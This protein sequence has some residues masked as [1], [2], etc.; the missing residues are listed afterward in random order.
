MSNLCDNCENPSWTGE[1]P[2]PAPPYPGGGEAGDFDDLSNRP[3]YDS[4]ELT[5]STNIPKVPTTA[6]SGATASEDG[7]KG[8]VPAPDSGQEG[9]YLKGDGSWGDVE[10]AETAAQLVTDTQQAQISSFPYRTSGGTL[11]IDS[12]KAELVYVK[13]K[14]VEVITVTNNFEVKDN[15]LTGSP[16]VSINETV[17]MSL[18]WG[19]HADTYTFTTL[20]DGKVSVESEDGTI[21]QLVQGWFTPLTGIIM[22]PNRAAMQSVGSSVTIEFTQSSTMTLKTAKP[23]G[24]ES[25][26]Y[27][28]APGADDIRLIADNEYRINCSSFTSI[29]VTPFD[30]SAIY[31]ITPDENNK[32]TPAKSGWGHVNDGVGQV[33]IALVWSGSRDNDPWESTWFYEKDIPMADKN[34]NA[35]PPA[36]YGFPSVGDVAD[37]V[38][39]HNKQYIQRV[40]HYAYSAENLEIVQALDT[41]YTY[42]STDIFYVLDEPIVYELPEYTTGVYTVNDYGTEWFIVDALGTPLEIPLETKIIYGSNLVDKLRNLADIQEVGDGLT[43]DDGML[44]SSSIIELTEADYNYPENAPTSVALWLLKPGFYTRGTGVSVNITTTTSL[45]SD[46]V[47]VVGKA[48]PFGQ[49]IYVLYASSTA[50]DGFCFC[51]IYNVT[52]LGTSS[53]TT[54]LCAPVNALT[55]T[56]VNAPLSANQGRV[57]KELVDSL[58]FKNA[59]APTTATV[60]AVGQ[61]LEDTTNGKLY[62][63]TTADTVTPAYTWVEVGA[64]GGGGGSI[65]ELTSADYNYPESGTKTSVALWKLPAG[66]YYADNAASLNTVLKVYANDTSEYYYYSTFLVFEDAQSQGYVTIYG[67]MGSDGNIGHIWKVW[68][69]NGNLS[70]SLSIPTVE[71]IQNTFQSAPEVLYVDDYDYPEEDPDGIAVWNLSTNTNYTFYE[72]VK[73]YL[74]STTSFTCSTNGRLSIGSTSG[75]NKFFEFVICENG[76]T[77]VTAGFGFTNYSTGAKVTLKSY[78][79]S[80]IAANVSNN[81]PNIPAPTYPY[82]SG[83]RTYYLYNGVEVYVNQMD[84]SQNLYYASDNSLAINGGEWGDNGDGTVSYVGGGSEEPAPEEPTEEPVEG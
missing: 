2:I 53:M 82:T 34:G 29:E 70:D 67:L 45:G 50:A 24:F 3:K 80:D 81:N 10:Y 77:D 16:A 43:L 14:T 64:G 84:A 66:L 12:G 35:L 52:W 63:C 74:N 51:D 33:L 11:S 65:T 68:K 8:L 69:Q 58:V 41:T 49:P 37:E 44:S 5:G 7:T 59:G 72:P 61:L 48:G 47:A 27:N 40:G 39:Y 30:G 75:S 83:S 20:A 60:G 22:V 56:S 76:T 1:D 25:V 6:F 78:T 55:S 13:G 18:P 4:T 38:N 62:I 46:E 54:T 79:T 57:L 15:S 73:V 21:S 31:T 19:A 26:G 71:Y 32:F 28:Q 36:S 17:W 9:Q 23:I 42:D